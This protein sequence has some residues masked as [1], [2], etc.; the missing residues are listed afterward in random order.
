MRRTLQ[1]VVLLAAT[2]FA[3][4]GSPSTRAFDLGVDTGVMHVTGSQLSANFWIARLQQP[5]ALILDPLAIR[6]R[7]ERLLRTDPSLHD[8]AALPTA[9]RKG[10]VQTWVQARSS[11][12]ARALYDDTGHRIAAAAVENWL[13]SLALDAIPDVQPT[14]F[15]LIVQRAP[16][17]TFPTAQRV[18]SAPGDHDIDRFQETAFFPGTPVAIVHESRDRK[19]WFVVGKFYAAWVEK[20]FVA[21]GGRD[22]VLGYAGKSPALIVTG[23]TVRTTFTPQLPEVSHLQLDMGTQVSLWVGWPGAKPVNGQAAY[24]SNVIELPVRNVDGSL[25]I[26]PALLPRTDAMATAPLPLTS[27]NILRQ[28]FKFLGE[29]YGWGHDYDARDCSGFVSEV[30]RSMGVDLPRNTGD[31]ARMAVYDRLQVRPGEDAK[32][33]DALLRDLDV[34]DLVFI[35]G[36]VMLVIGHVDGVPWVIHDIQKTAWLD[37]IGKL[38]QIPLNGVSVTPLPQLRRDRKTTYVDLITDI[39]R[40]RPPPESGPSRDRQAPQP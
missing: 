20:R 26:V 13:D 10:Q 37:A 30:Y 7:N 27:A 5:D 39:Q 36:H 33:R 16:L 14:R 11:R 15:G 32:R 22:R 2:M 24:A 18:F 17:R 19:W 21:E 3:V 12:P 9:L 35:P 8:I 29:R 28:A 23:A 1:I 4:A 6:A 25:R 40:I 31:Q 38:Q 34:G